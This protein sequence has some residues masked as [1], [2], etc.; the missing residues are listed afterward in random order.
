MRAVAS[1]VIGIACI[2]ALIIGVSLMIAGVPFAGV[3]AR[4][5]PRA[6]HRAVASAIVTLPVI[7]WIWTSGDYGTDP[8]AAYSVS[9]VRR[10]HGRQ[11]P[12][13][14]DARPRRRCA[15]A[16]DPDRRARRHGDRPASSACSSAPSLLALGYQIFMRWVADNPERRGNRPLP[17]PPPPPPEPMR[18]AS[19]APGRAFL[20][21]RGAVA[22]RLRRGRAGLQAA[23]GALAG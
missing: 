2:Q 13:A 22:R 18:R 10:R 12:E 1:G 6:R 15:D 4:G 7:G 23:R 20:P 3:L 14:A 17:I 8:A 21:R 9:A 19:P 5:R 16:G 11:R